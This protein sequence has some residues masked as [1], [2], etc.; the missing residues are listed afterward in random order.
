MT[1][2]LASEW[3]PRGI[4]LNA[5]APGTFPTQGAFERL[6]P[7][8]ELARGHE[9]NNALGRPGD[10]QELAALAAFLVSDASTYIQGECVTLDGG[11]LG[12]IW[13]GPSASST[14]SRLRIGKRWR[15]GSRRVRAAAMAEAR[16]MRSGGRLAR[17]RALQER[18][19]EGAGGRGDARDRRADAARRGRR[20]CCARCSARHLAGRWTMSRPG[21][22]R[23]SRW[24]CPTPSS[25]TSTSAC[26]SWWMPCLARAPPGRSGALHPGLGNLPH[27]ADASE[28]DLRPGAPGRAGSA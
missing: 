28:L 25:R 12:R 26:P 13:R 16:T 8:S 7:R 22:A 14:T 10:P 4:R 27:P 15:P 11:T 19:A 1:R 3:G 9:T 23:P 20:W 18:F 2:S 21:S 17:L 6:V 5:L 24:R